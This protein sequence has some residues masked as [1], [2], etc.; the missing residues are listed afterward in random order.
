MGLKSRRKR[1]SKRGKERVRKGGGKERPL[2]SR[3]N[4]NT[5]KFPAGGTPHGNRG[6]SA[7]KSGP[8]QKDLAEEGNRGTAK[9]RRP[10]ARV[11]T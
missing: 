11:T 7:K 4:R 6:G 1:N 9:H 8:K 5:G 3:K 10:G 2:C